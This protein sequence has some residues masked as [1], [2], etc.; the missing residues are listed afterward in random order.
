MFLSFRRRFFF[1]FTPIYPPLIPFIKVNQLP[2]LEGEKLFNFFRESERHDTR[3]SA[4]LG[5]RK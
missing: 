4:E 5:M 3:A 1:F 2:V